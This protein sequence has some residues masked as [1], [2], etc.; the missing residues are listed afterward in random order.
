LHKTFVQVG[1]FYIWILASLTLE[2]W[3]LA[4]VPEHA[5]MAQFPVLPANGGSLDFLASGWQPEI[6]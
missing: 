3:V 2:I 6:G 5:S 4:T 1:N